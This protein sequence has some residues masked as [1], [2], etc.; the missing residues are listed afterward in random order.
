MLENP[1]FVEP[2]G[3]ASQGKPT[4]TIKEKFLYKEMANETFDTKIGDS[5][6]KLPDK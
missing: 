2:Q 5:F 4:F 6:M 3:G 1:P